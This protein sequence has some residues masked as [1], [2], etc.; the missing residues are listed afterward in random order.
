MCQRH[1]Q[2]DGGA[3]IDGGGDGNHGVPSNQRRCHTDLHR[4]RRPKGGMNPAKGEGCIPRCRRLEKTY[5][6]LTN[7]PLFHRSDLQTCESHR[8]MQ[9]RD[10]D[11]CLIRA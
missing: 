8:S 3:E 10:L 7:A 11:P 5:S 2:R 6:H 1:V 9:D 4:S